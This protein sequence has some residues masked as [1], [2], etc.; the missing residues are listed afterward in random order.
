VGLRTLGP[1]L[2]TDGREFFT[3]NLVHGRSVYGERLVQFQGREYRVWSPRR[4]KLAALLAKGYRDLPLAGDSK[5]LYLGAAT[6]TTA[7]HLSDM[8]PLG[9]VHCVE[10]S[11]TAFRKLLDLAR[12]RPNI[13][14]IL[15]DATQ[16]SGYEGAVGRVDVVY[17]DVAQRDQ[18]GIL[19]RN[20][21]MLRHGGV[22][23]LMLK[24]RSV[25]ISR[26]PQEIYQEVARALQDRGLDLMDLIDLAPLE[27]DHAALLLRLP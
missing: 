21:S 16:P 2:L 8:V 19:L 9:A 5:V 4:S 10:V 15:G 23:L 3:E 18:A 20:L 24:A 13:I 7:S 26:R 17:Q 22:A 6:G 11:P 12:A 25:D 14:P 1:H 27:K